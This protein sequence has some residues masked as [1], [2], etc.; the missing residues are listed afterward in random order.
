MYKLGSHNTM[1]YLK[2]KYWYMYPFKWFA[3]CQ[4]KDIKYQYELGI[5]YFDIRIRYDE[6]G[7]PEFAHGLV[8]YKSDVT[9]VLQELNNLGEEVKVRLILE[10]SE[11]PSNDNYLTM[12]SLFFRRDCRRWVRRFKN[13]KFH[14][15]RRKFDWEQIYHFKNVEPE[16]DQKISS[17]QGSKADDLFPFIYALFNNSKNTKKGTDKEYMLLDF[18][19]INSYGDKG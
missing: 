1:T 5:R 2:P 6:N 16:L 7:V 14:C 9:K 17:M 3:Q 15:G 4:N 11:N 10:I 18:V 19:Q 12:Q 13:I 8:S